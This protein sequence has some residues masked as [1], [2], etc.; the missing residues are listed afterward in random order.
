M[1]IRVFK[2]INYKLQFAW[3]SLSQNT[4]AS[5]P[6]ENIIAIYYVIRINNLQ[7][8]DDKVMTKCPFIK[9]ALIKWNFIN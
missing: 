7:K 1:R 6:F 8:I 4:T 5:Y 9:R 2:Y 3:W